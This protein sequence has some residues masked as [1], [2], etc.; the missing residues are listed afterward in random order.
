M[1]AGYGLVELIASRHESFPF[2]ENRSALVLARPVTPHPSR[3]A[4]H[5]ANVGAPVD[6]V[7]DLIGS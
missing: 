7:S 2:D 6:R 1:G 5:R 4:V 3:A